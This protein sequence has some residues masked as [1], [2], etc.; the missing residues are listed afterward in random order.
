MNTQLVVFDIAGTTVRDK[1]HVAAAFIA[2]FKEHNKEVS[3]EEVNMIMGFRKKDA[4]RIMLEKFPYAHQQNGTLI[5]SIHASF[6]RN[7][8]A[9]YE[10]DAELSPLPDAEATF[11]WLHERGIQIALNTGFTRIVTNTILDRLGWKQHSFID[12]VI[13][14]DEVLHGRPLPYMIQAIMR[15]LQVADSKDVIKVGDTQVDIEEGRN[16]GCGL[17]I[18]VTTGAYTRD[19]LEPFQPDHIID[20]LSEL[21]SIINNK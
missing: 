13:C 21:T 1:G 14:S 3:R 7:I 10:N 6:T 9:A 4:I 20:S 8:I 11:Q 15:Q 16:A 19:Q 2:A 12:M 18:S 5:D 17:V